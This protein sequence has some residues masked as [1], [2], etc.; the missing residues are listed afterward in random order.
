MTE[1][2]AQPEFYMDTDQIQVKKQAELL[3]ARGAVGRRYP[4]EDAEAETAFARGLA[5]NTRELTRRNTADCG[6]ER[7][8]LRLADGT[9]D[10]GLLRARVVPQ[11]FGGLGLATA[12]AAVAADAAIVR[13]AK[14]MWQAYEKVST[15]LEQMGEED[16][17]HENCGA[18]ESVE[19]SVANEIDPAALVPAILMMTQP[20][21]GS[22]SLIRHNTVHKRRLLANGFY[23]AWDPRKHLDYLTARFPSNVSYIETDPDDALG[24]HNGSGLYLIDEENVGF[25]KNAFIDDTGRW[26]FCLTLPKM[27]Q[28]AHMIGGSEEERERILLGFLDDSLHVGGGIVAEGMP[29]FG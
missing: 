22:E 16:A 21:D 13:D 1:R 18:S 27:R 19:T 26:A 3:F 24:G 25:A 9:D 5:S 14:S 6:D 12:K 7:R 29:V 23:S 2:F 20:K 17:G 4:L 8:L 10:P 28:I 15:V 11:M